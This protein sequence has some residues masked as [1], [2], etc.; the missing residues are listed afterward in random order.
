M[1]GG[2]GEGAGPRS[3]PRAGRALAA[4][5]RDLA[6]PGHE[7][8]GARLRA[9][10]SA[11]GVP[12]RDR[13]APESHPGEVPVDPIHRSWEDRLMSA[14]EIDRYLSEIDEPKRTT[15]SRLR[16]SILEVIPE[17]EEGLA[18]GMP[19]FRVGG[20]VVAGFAAF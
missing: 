3:V 15:L 12:D 6:R 13:A 8:P 17:A 11:H 20:K 16:A 19:A 1:A 4:A 2:A 7:R 14:E 10:G 18:Y 9:G 5:V